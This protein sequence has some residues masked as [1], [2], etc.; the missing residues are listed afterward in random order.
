MD[1]SYVRR[2]LQHVSVL[3]AIMVF[4]LRSPVNTGPLVFLHWPLFTY[5]NTGFLVAC[6]AVILVY[7]TNKE[8]TQSYTYK[9]TKRVLHQYKLRKNIS[10]VQLHAVELE[11]VWRLYCGE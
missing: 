2:F 3:K 6:N 4:F 5:W 10:T 9:P 7:S 11:Q 1:T 8:K